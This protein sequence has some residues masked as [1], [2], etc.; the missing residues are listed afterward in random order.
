MAVDRLVPVDPIKK[1]D[2]ITTPDVKTEDTKADNKVV[3]EKVK[4]EDALGE[5]EE[6]EVEEVLMCVHQDRISVLI[7]EGTFGHIF[8]FIPY[9]L[10]C[11]C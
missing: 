8:I 5:E 1:E 4:K 9:I 10:L 2:G 7:Q 3:E 11:K 6:D